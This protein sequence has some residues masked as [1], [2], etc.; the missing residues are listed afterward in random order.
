MCNYNMFRED[1]WMRLIKQV[2]ELFLLKQP[3]FHTIFYTWCTCSLVPKHKHIWKDIHTQSPS[4]S[5]TTFLKAAHQFSSVFAGE[6]QLCEGLYDVKQCWR[7]TQEGPGCFYNPISLSTSLQQSSPMIHC[8]LTTIWNPARV[9]LYV[10]TPDRPKSAD[11]CKYYFRLVL[12]WFS[13]LI[14]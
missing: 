9:R 1:K 6:E 2:N 14:H 5:V 13:W 8:A 4:V 10:A 12:S 3:H 11:E 7:E